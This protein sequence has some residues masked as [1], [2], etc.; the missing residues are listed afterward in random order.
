MNTLLRSELVR[1]STVPAPLLGAAAVAITSLGLVAVGSAVVPPEDV[2]GIAAVLAVPP[3]LAVVVLLVLGALGGASDFQ[4]RTADMTFLARPRRSQVLMS[5]ATV[6][7][8]VGVALAAVTS[9]GCAAVAHAIVGARGLELPGLASVAGTSAGSVIAGALCGA[10]GVGVGYA[11]RSSVPAVL[12][13]I[14]WAT[15]GEGLLGTV[16]PAPLLPIGAARILGAGPTAGLTATAVA[17]A[18]LVAYTV[19]ALAVGTRRLRR[20]LDA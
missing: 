3:T 11:V 6:Y 1:L 19:V 18:V 12:G 2:L 14:A 8:A 17:A 13:V 16:V 5:R 9:A 20:D 4:H 10:L 7:A 15:V